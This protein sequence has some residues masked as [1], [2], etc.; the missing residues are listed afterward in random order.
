[1]SEL[2]TANLTPL[3]RDALLEALQSPTHS[4]QRTSAGYVVP[5][6]RTRS[7]ETASAR[8]FTSRV[9]NRLD[10]RALVDL[11]PPM[12]PARAVLT[13]RGVAAAQQVLFER[14]APVNER[15]LKAVQR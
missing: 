8:I 11:D 7:G 10:R 14:L 6:R 15:L 12:C 5:S 1:M 4:L 9:M 3:E 2:N 13:R